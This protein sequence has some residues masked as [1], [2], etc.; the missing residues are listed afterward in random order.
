MSTWISLNHP[1]TIV[2]V[3]VN[4]KWHLDII[5][6]IIN[7]FQNFSGAHRVS[8]GTFP[9]PVLF[10][11]LHIKVVW[12]IQSAWITIKT[13]IVNFKRHIRHSSI[14]NHSIKF[15]C[16]QSAFLAFTILIRRD[17]PADSNWQ[18]YVTRGRPSQT[19]L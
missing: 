5:P 6:S 1:T 12:A 11:N 9:R 18:L 19:W 13:V 4:F 16:T 8:L 2:I 15:C 17:Y 10:E 14:F 7:Y 3:I